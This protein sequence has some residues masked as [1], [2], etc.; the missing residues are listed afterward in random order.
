MNNLEEI[1]SLP[2]GENIR[3]WL[4]GQMKEN[5][6][7]FLLAFA[8]DGVIWGR[9]DGTSLTIAHDVDSSYP[10]LRGKTLLE[11]RAFNTKTEVHLF[12]NELGGWK[13][14]KI[15]DEGD[16]IK[17]SQILWGD[18]LAEEQPA[19]PGFLRLT[20]ERKGIPVQLI[21]ANGKFNGN[22]CI[23]LEVHHLVG[24]TDDGE[25]YIK[26]SRLAGLRV[27]KKDE[28]V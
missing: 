26:L 10:E 19:Q 22:D 20:A 16:V 12:R 24:Y 7:S 3:E 18:Q 9:H 11:A 14:F 21:P 8:D 25:A 1:K 6:L 2:T 4:A 28:E 23:R 15:V 5:N 13:A 17:E 27:G